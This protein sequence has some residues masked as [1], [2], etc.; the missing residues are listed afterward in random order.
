[1][2]GLK[3]YLT[4]SN[5]L[6]GW[7]RRKLSFFSTNSVNK[8][9]LKLQW[10]SGLEWV[11][12]V[13]SPIYSTV[14]KDVSVTMKLQTCTF[15]IVEAN[16]KLPCHCQPLLLLHIWGHLPILFLSV[17]I[18]T[19]MPC[20]STAS[21]SSC[22]KDLEHESQRNPTCTLNASLWAIQVALNN[23]STFEEDRMQ[24]LTLYF[25]GLVHAVYSKSTSASS[26]QLLPRACNCYSCYSLNWAFRF[27]LQ[28][29]NY[30]C[31]PRK[32]ISNT[33]IIYPV[34]LEMKKKIKVMKPVF[35]PHV[36]FK[37]LHV[38]WARQCCTCATLIK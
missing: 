29:V 17:F 32:K 1:M 9:F 8:E 30:F 36:V 34:N 31:I 21:K 15:F 13:A 26:A 10:G 35:W 5:G 25:S 22:N 11:W 23:F 16:P 38:I 14:Q 37:L 20:V 12:W 19:F 24:G 33:W 4:S 3:S 7:R 27:V 6:L 28:T 2:L 18:S